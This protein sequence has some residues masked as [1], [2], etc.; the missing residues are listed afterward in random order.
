ME[1]EKEKLT[2]E[3]LA[4]HFMEL[5]KETRVKARENDSDFQE[6]R[7]NAYKHAAMEVREQLK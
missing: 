7:A 6:G 5:S 3:D 2:P 4:G 1:E